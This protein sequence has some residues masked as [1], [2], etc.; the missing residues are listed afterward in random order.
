MVLDHQF[1]ND[2]RVENEADTLFDEVMCKRK[3]KGDS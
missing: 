3:N 1:P 2:A